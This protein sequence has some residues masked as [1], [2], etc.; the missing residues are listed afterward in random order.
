MFCVAP[1]ILF[2]Y[3]W[4]RLVLPLPIG[5]FYKAAFAFL[6]CAA[7][8][9]Q[10]VFVKFGG[11]FAPDLPRWAIE[12]YG[13]AF[14]MLILLF[15]LTLLKDI[16]IIA[17]TIAHILIPSVPLLHTN[18]L[19][20][21]V[22]FAAAMLLTIYGNYEAQRLPGVR[23]L[24]INVKDLPKEFDGYKIALLS[25]IHISAQRGAPYAEELVKRV[26][27]LS[28]DSVFIAG[29]FVDG[30]VEPRSADVAPL[31]GLK[32]RDV[33]VGVLGNH[34]YYFNPDQ[35]KD[36]IENRLG[37]KILLNEHKIIKRGEASI[38]VAGVADLAALRF[39]GEKRK[40]QQK[41]LAGIPDG[42][43]KLAKQRSEGFEPPDV[44]K[45][46][47]GI[48]EGV[49]III[50]DHQPGAAQ[51]NASAGAE[52]QLSGHTHGGMVPILYAIVKKSNNGFVKGLYD[53]GGM[54]LYVSPGTGIWNG[55]M[56]RIGVPSEI[57]L[58]TL[59]PAE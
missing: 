28:P 1:I 34:E 26:N 44:E 48:P 11:F 27:V 30:F 35:W 53:V 42:V 5:S 15:V 2:L 36:Y 46:L 54:T 3:V 55:F 4:F 8:L 13:A 52:V 6:L 43:A 29:D 37:I 14:N 19:T 39:E 38:A 21:S 58:I 33:V 7:S 51:R 25:D 24:T 40:K 59:K 49:P 10:L 9:K 18:I 56:M 32:A 31:S 22:I 16:V 41:G 45:A 57:T 17:A 50:L 20:S 47:S 23:E 12:I